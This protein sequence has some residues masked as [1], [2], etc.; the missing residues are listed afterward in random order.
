M[1]KRL[2]PPVRIGIS[3]CL[4]GE[5]VRYDG[6]HK[7]DPFICRTLSGFFE[8]IPVCPEAEAGFGIPREPMRLEKHDKSISLIG[9]TTRLDLTRQMRSYIRR[10]IPHLARHQ[11]SGYILKTR[12]P[13]C[14]LAVA[15]HP[16]RS[17]EPGL[18]ARALLRRFSDLPVVEEE[19]LRDPLVRE[20][21]IQRVF[22]YYRLN[23]FWGTRWTVHTL[24]E[25]HASTELTRLSHS[26]SL[27]RRLDQFT[28]NPQDLS[29]PQLRC[30]YQSEFMR[31][32][33]VPATRARNATVMKRT[34]ASLRPFLKSAAMTEILQS[35]DAYRTGTL[36]FLAP[37]TLI[38]HYLRLARITQPSGQT[39]FNPFPEE[40]AL[41]NHP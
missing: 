21:W 14:G 7:L 38:T 34:A 40:L 3:S 20:T 13:S 23:R 26:P 18:F 27:S 37:F 15:V 41:L 39:Y 5:N 1:A 6:G 35:L 29:R 28:A 17:R 25:F 31:I 4:L 32:I 16:G 19:E 12:S 30:R 10:S 22:A 8:W 33:S 2:D 11:L 36:P 9:L 24:R